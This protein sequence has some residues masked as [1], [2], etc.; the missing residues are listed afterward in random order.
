MKRHLTELDYLRAA[1]RLN[2]PEP[3]CLMAVA[4]TESKGEGFYPDGF[5]TILFERH[6]FY[7][8]ADPSRRAEWFREFPDICNP[9]RTKRG[10]YGSKNAQRDKFN[11]AFALD[12]NA[13]MMACSW[14][15]FQE[16]GE[17]YDDYKFKS[18]GEFVDMM[19]SGI[20]GQLEIFTR[21]LKKRG[22]I[23]EM[24]RHDWAG[25]ARIYNGPAYKEFNYDTQMAHSFAMFKARKIDW[26][27]LLRS[28]QSEQTSAAGGSIAASTAASFTGPA[29][30]E[31]ASSPT[32]PQSALL[33]LTVGTS[34]TETGQQPGPSLTP[35]AEQQSLLPAPQQ[36]QQQDLSIP[37]KIATPE[38]YNGIGFWATIKKDIA[39]VGAGNLGFQSLSEY[40]QQASGWPPWVI[41]IVTKLAV[42]AVILTAGYFLFR[43]VHYLVDSWKKQ[44]KVRTEADINSDPS[45]RDIRWT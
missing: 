11:R 33:N 28:S 44:Q 8:N 3:E 15:A 20:D 43:V 30:D 39:A 5:P 26:A 37:A 40:A 13:A 41:G 42:L 34:D 29:G 1:Q 38:P 21:S 12:P 24:R 32:N 31:D 6:K 16:L 23:D 18:V 17:N 4:E 7:K 35:A 10:G 19:K 2:L 45:R 9:N 14:G 25:I 36:P 27:A 22:L